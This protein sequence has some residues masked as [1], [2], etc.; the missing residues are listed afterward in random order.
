ME[1]HLF[2]LNTGDPFTP[3]KLYKRKLMILSSHS[4]NK[5]FHNGINSHGEEAD[6]CFQSF[7]KM[8]EGMSSGK[9]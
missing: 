3:M 8:N 5:F 4:Q 2:F 6:S 1:T 9:L 7:P